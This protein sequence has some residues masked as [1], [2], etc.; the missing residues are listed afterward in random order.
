MLNSLRGV[1]EIRATVQKLLW[2][3]CSKQCGRCSSRS[4]KPNGTVQGAMDFTF[5]DTENEAGAD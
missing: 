3:Q 5:I 4:E 2:S 1:I